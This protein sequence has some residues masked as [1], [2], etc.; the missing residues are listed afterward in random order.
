MKNDDLVFSVAYMGAPGVIV[1]WLA[2]GTELPKALQFNQ[3][4]IDEGFEINQSKEEIEKL[5]KKSNLKL[6]S[7]EDGKTLVS[8]P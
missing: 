3:Y 6:E 5:A 8:I 2:S 4:L 7:S 1:K